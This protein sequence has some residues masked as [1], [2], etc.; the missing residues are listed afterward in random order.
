MSTASIARRVSSVRFDVP[1]KCAD[2][3]H[4]GDDRPRP[5]SVDRVPARP[6]EAPHTYR[7][8]PGVWRSPRAVRW[9]RSR[10]SPTKADRDVR[11]IALDT[12][13]RTSVA[14]VRVLCAR[15]FRIRPTFDSSGPRS[16]RDARRRPT[17]RCIIGD[18][19]LFLEV[20]RP[21]RASSKIDL[22]EVWTRCDRPAVRVCVLGGP[23][24]C[25]DRRTTWRNC[26]GRAM[27][28]ITRVAEIAARLF[29][30]SARNRRLGRATCGI[31]SSTTSATTSVPASSCSTATRPK[32]ASCRARSRCGSIELIA[33]AGPLGLPRRR[34]R[35]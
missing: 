32:P 16:R 13:S 9:R 23:A 28:G 17:R 22:G 25:A 8:V 33:S 3:L 20:G 27:Q 29:Q 11:S 6:V 15:E 35:S 18:N 19:A 26:S 4:E 30:R 1:S 10:S 34:N 21:R 24:R 7:I 14:L 31:I 5:D 2:L 12:S